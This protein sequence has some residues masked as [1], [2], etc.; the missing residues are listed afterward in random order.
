MRRLTLLLAVILMGFAFNATA[1]EEKS[2]AS[3]Y[4][5]GIAEKKAGNYEAAMGLFKEAIAATEG[6]STETAMKVYDSAKKGF[7][8]AAYYQG[9]DLRKAK[10]YEGAI[11]VFDEGLAMSDLYV[12]YPL[13]ASALDKAGR[14]EEAVEVYFT[15]AEKYAE[16]GKPEEKVVSYYKRGMSLLY[17][18]KAWDKMIEKATA[19][20]DLLKDASNAYYVAK[21]YF[22]KSKYEEAVAAIDQGLPLL[23][24]GKDNGKFLMLKGDSLAKLGKSSEAAAAYNSIAADSKYA[25]RAK[26]L[27]GQLK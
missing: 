12:I 6:D 26:Y 11:A 16:A 9:K 21:A 3:I 23:E 24:E 13:K 22:N 4:N 27:A 1:Q 7:T 25:E 19:Y 14:K 5:E 15:S 17:K 10:D 20:P 18:G 8:Q 2:A